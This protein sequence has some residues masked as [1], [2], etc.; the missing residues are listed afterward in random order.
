[1]RLDPRT[2]SVVLM[3]MLAH[4]AGRGPVLIAVDD[5]QWLD[6]PTA[7]ALAFAARRLDREPVGLLA[8]VR[9]PV[10]I[11]DPL[12]LE[13]ALDPERVTHLRLGPLSLAALRRVF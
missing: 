11:P 12:G 6:A 8:T 9:S 7:P 13:H 10:T 3:S 1:M 2:F 5:L 4:V